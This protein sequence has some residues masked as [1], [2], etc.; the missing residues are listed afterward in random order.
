VKIGASEHTRQILTTT[1]E[2]CPVCERV[3]RENNK[4]KTQIEALVMQV[5]GSEGGWGRRYDTI[6]F[7]EEVCRECY[8]ALQPAVKQFLKVLA[9][10][11]G[12]N[13]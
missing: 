13:R 4:P 7:S 6:R 5:G 1:I 3:L 9:D 12:V 8:E 11:N 2:H 10:R